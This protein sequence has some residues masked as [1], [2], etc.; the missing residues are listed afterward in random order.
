[1]RKYAYKKKIFSDMRKS[2]L[3]SGLLVAC[4]KLPCGREALSFRS[5]IPGLSDAGVEAWYDLQRGYANMKVEFSSDTKIKDKDELIVKINTLNSDYVLFHLA[6]CPDCGAL[7]LRSG[8]YV[9][10]KFPKK[11]F[12]MLI[13]LICCELTVT[14][15]EI[16]ETKGE[17]K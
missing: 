11:K 2:F 15:S 4:D 12:K 9:P 5:R 16:L 10:G 1:M 7:E 8:M 6:I 3:E 14:V 17:Q 13:E